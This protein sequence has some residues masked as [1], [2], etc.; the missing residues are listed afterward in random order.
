MVLHFC[1]FCLFKG[2]VM[3]THS[4]SQTIYQKE[5]LEKGGICFVINIP[6]MLKLMVNCQELCFL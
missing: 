4:R 1:S 5:A 6:P 2:D 3:T